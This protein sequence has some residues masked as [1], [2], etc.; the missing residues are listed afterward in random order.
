MCIAVLTHHIRQSMPVFL[1]RGMVQAPWSK[2]SREADHGQPLFCRVVR[3]DATVG[4]ASRLLDVEV[5]HFAG[6]ALVI[7]AQEVR[8]RQRS[9]GAQTILRVLVPRVPLTDEDTD[10]KRQGGELAVARAHQG[11]PLP[12]VCS[13]QLYT[14]RPLMPERVGP[15]GE[16]LV[17]QLPLRRDRTP[18]LPALSATKFAHALGGIPTVEQPIDLESSGEQRLQLRQPRLSQR[19]VL[20]KAPPLRWGPLSVETPPRLLAQVTSPIVR[21]GPGTARSADLNRYGPLGGGGARL[22][23][24]RGVVMMGFDGFE[25]PGAPVFFAQRVIQAAIESPRVTRVGVSHH[26]CHEHVAQRRAHLLGRPGTDAP[27]V[28]PIRRVGGIDQESRETGHGFMPC[29]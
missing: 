18:D 28:R 27:R 24:T 21:R 7:E 12:L 23:R 6:P 10:R 20:A 26:V 15:V 4:Q 19:R 1:G 9:V 3:R 25:M 17:V 8:C 11:G 5:V 13:G 22:P 29:F 16:L 2:P 14:L